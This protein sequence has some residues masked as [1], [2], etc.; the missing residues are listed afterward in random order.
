MFRDSLC[1]YKRCV[2]G[3][4]TLNL[5]R[6]RYISVK[7]INIVIIK[8]L[9]LASSGNVS[10]IYLDSL[11]GQW[12]RV[13]KDSFCWLLWPQCL[14]IFC[15]ERWKRQQRNFKKKTKH[16][17]PW[18]TKKFN[19][20]YSRKILHHKTSRKVKMLWTLLYREEAYKLDFLFISIPMDIKKYIF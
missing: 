9:K 10:S 19:N 7:A 8:F 5:R 3:R 12:C 2:P 20:S 15:L 1:R 6:R 4:G 17:I 14:Q 13:R 16:S 11:I 18:M